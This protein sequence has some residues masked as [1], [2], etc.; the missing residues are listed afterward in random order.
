MI[1]R[2]VRLVV[3]CAGISIGMA[4][5]VAAQ[6]SKASGWVGRVIVTAEG[7]LLGRVEDLAVDV[8][9]KRVDFVVVSIGSFLIDDNL[10][11][12]HPDALGLSEDGEYLVVYAENLDKAARFGIDNWPSKAD[13]MPSS[14]RKSVVVDNIVAS[15]AESG[16]NEDRR[17]TISDGRRTATMKAGEGVAQIE[18]SGNR[19]IR[20]T[21]TQAE[22]QPKLFQARDTAQ[23]LLADSE[24]ERMDDNSD[25][26]LSRSEIGARLNQNVRYQDYDLDSNDGIDPFEFQ[27]LKERG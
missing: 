20:K 17:A 27:I 4:A 15:D 18:R 25:G 19:D 22:V 9:A 8:E 24:F 3:V 5:P 12:V 10:I 1:S 7:E 6:T 13:V 26:Y 21:A 2:L 11:A 16:L 23:P 14:E